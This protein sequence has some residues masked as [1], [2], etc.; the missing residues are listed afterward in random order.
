MCL[1]VSFS[2]YAKKPSFVARV[3]KMFGCGGL[4]TSQPLDPEVAQ[5]AKAHP[6]TIKVTE[7]KEE[8]GTFHIRSRIYRP[9]L[10]DRKNLAPDAT[11]EV[12]FIVDG[13]TVR[14]PM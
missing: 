13:E 9:K 14:V 10:F 8:P 5:F 11:D 1:F 6:E 7:D 3:A 4:L 2:A 12:N